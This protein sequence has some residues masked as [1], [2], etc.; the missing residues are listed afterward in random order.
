[1]STRLYLLG[2]FLLLLYSTLVAGSAA[3]RVYAQSD[4]TAP[5]L[6]TPAP[7]PPAPHM[8]APQDL[9]GLRDFGKVSETIYRGGPPHAEGLPY[10][11][12]LGIKTI[13]DLR[14]IRTDRRVL[15]G[16]GFQ[17]VR[18]P[19]FAWYPRKIDVL[20]F[21]KVVSDPA[22]CPVYVHCDYG[23]DRVGVM[24][25]CYRMVEQHWPRDVAMKEYR[26]YRSHP[27]VFDARPFLHRLNPETLAQMLPK[28]DMPHVLVFTADGDLK[29]RS[30][31]AN[32]TI[33]ASPRPLSL[34]AS[35]APNTAT[36]DPPESL[37]EK[38]IEND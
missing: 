15:K 5:A 14:L 6:A 3:A 27:E 16:S 31:S 34:E 13:I 37:P 28:T 35:P 36:E 20:H 19:F 24:I 9:P 32:V 12:K 7:A 26:L 23:A 18:I 25:A 33:P 17:Y 1:M 11:K 10:L 4:Q 21:L 29:P 22:N 38:G 30:V 2:A 8:V